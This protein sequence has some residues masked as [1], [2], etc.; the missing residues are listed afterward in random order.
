MLLEA[1]ASTR[2]RCDIVASVAPDL[3]EGSRL[4]VQVYPPGL[5]YSLHD[6]LQ[7]GFSNLD[8]PSFTQTVVDQELLKITQCLWTDPPIASRCRIT[9]DVATKG[10]VGQRDS[11]HYFGLK[12]FGR[13]SHRSKGTGASTAVSAAARKRCNNFWSVALTVR[14]GSGRLWLNAWCSTQPCSRH[15][16]HQAYPHLMQGSPTA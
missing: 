1:C 3:Y 4:I 9:T 13:I 10:G 12:L 11:F 7:C 15:H 14:T 2:R 6:V 8:D 5:P 16:S